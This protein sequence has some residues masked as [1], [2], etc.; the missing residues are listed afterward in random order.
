MGKQCHCNT[1]HVNKCGNT[2][3]KKPKPSCKIPK[4]SCKI[5]ESTLNSCKCIS[6]PSI[7]DYTCKIQATELADL[8]ELIKQLSD[9][10]DSFECRIEY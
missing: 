1:V 8:K 3:Y 4:P 5:Y 9:R 7:D 2:S 6:H 10:I